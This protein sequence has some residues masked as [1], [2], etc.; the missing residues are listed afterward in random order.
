[1]AKRPTE[2]PRRRNRA[3]VA[4]GEELRRDKKERVS[5]RG[6]TQSQVKWIERQ[7]AD[8]YVRKAM[9]EGWRS[10]AA[11][12][13][14]ELDDRWGVIKPGAMVVDLGAAPGG[15]SQVA[16]ARG[17]ARVVGI[18][19]LVTEALA[20]AEFLQMDFT[21]DDAPAAILDRLGAA[22]TLV[23]SDMAANTT[24]HR[25]TDHLR[26]VALAE[27]AAQFALETLAPGGS[28]CAK[29]FQGGSEGG[30]LNELK[31]AF[32][33][34]RHAKPPASRAQ[35]PEVYMLAEGFRGR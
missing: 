28:F 18:D 3:T 16:I 4:P 10:R 1:M 32:T 23:L 21:D 24:G 25:A 8:P 11:F 26:T 5:T 7:L 34:V 27:A 20:G 33:S 30:L 13:L 35:S 19:L 2:P 31:R 9:A 14:I 17:A 22:P 29:V 15:W 6:R 12:K